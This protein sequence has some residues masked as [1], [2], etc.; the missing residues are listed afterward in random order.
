MSKIPLRFRALKV[1]G[2][3]MNRRNRLRFSTDMIATI[4]GVDEPGISMKGRLANLSA[5][6]LSL[7]VPK[8]LFSGSTV[9]VEWGTSRV[10]GRIVYCQSYGNEFRTGLQ[11]E[12]PIYDAALAKKEDNLE[13][14]DLKISEE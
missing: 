2:I 5:H 13:T 10:V 9:K 12:D 14:S 6:G 7:I 4:T 3:Y 1:D 8:N 11:V